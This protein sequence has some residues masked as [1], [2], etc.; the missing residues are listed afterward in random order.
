LWHNGFWVGARD[1]A[2]FRTGEESV[3]SFPAAATVLFL[4]SLAVPGAPSFAGTLIARI[5]DTAGNPLPR[6]V[7]SL[8]GEA[9]KPAPAGPAQVIDQKNE[10]FVPDLV[11]V[12]V[13]GSVLFRN[14][15]APRHQV[16]SF[17]P[18]KRFE[19]ELAPGQQSDPIQFDR[20]GVV[21]LGCNIH[22]HMVAYVY[23]A[24][25]PAAIT[26]ANGVVTL[27]DVA[28]GSYQLQ[29]WH[30]RQRAGAA[31][32]APSPVTVAGDTEVSLQLAVAAPR[33]AGRDAER[34]PY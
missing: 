17:S 30:P 15:D 24:S 16:Y 29:L 14:S 21:A 33:P 34:A 5:T 26:D 28:D 2:Q 12:P 22:D 9:A 4:A 13:G 1:E 11:V 27:S 10:A 31:G 6:A 8:A 25:G 32:P 23:V 3:T 7:V 18:V 19:R 20:A